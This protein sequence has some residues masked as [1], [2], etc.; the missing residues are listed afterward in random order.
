MLSTPDPRVA[1]DRQP[2]TNAWFLDGQVF[3]D[4]RV[5][6]P[7][8]LWLHGG[9]GCGKTW[10]CTKIDEKLRFEASFKDRAATCYFSNAPATTDSRSGMCSLLSQLGLGR[11]IHPAIHNLQT[12]FAKT[13]SVLAPTS[14]QLEQ[15]LLDV[16][17]PVET[18]GQTFILVDALDEIPFGTCHS[19]RAR[20]TN[21]LNT[22]ANSQA[23]GFRILMTSRPHGDLLQSFTISHHAWKAYP[24]P[25]D[26]VQADIEISVRATIEKY[27]EE[28][29]IDAT[30]QTKL[31]ARLAGPKQTM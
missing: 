13:P 1:D 19:Q 5:G 28:W 31:I 16:V 30:F 15:T 4:W 25:D 22:L 21:L 24:I 10:L 2:G 8:A 6:D 11:K 26:K 3:H 29:K 17:E 7:K 20:V 18:E 23:P 14:D 12:E 9:M 27:A